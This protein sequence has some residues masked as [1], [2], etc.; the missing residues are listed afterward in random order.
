MSVTTADVLANAAFF[1]AMVAGLMLCLLPTSSWLDDWLRLRST[2]SAASEWWAL[3]F[4]LF[5]EFPSPS[6]EES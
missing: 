3:P 5:R 6:K 4:S 2:R 1:A